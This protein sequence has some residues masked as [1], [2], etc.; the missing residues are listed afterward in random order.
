MNVRKKSETDTLITIEWDQV[1]GQEGYVVTLD[2]SDVLADGRRHFS[3]SRTARSARISKVQDGQPHEYGV[4]I[5]TVQDQGAVTVP[6]PDEPPPPPPGRFR[7]GLGS[8]SDSGLSARIGQEAG[9]H[10]MRS[11][12]W[13][14]DKSASS[15]V[16][17]A[18]VYLDRGIEPIILFNE[19]NPEAAVPANL[20]AI[21][22]ALRPLNVTRFEWTNELLYNYKKGGG[23]AAPLA[24]SAVRASAAL[25]A[26]NPDAK[27][28]MP[29]DNDSGSSPE[30]IVND[31]YQAV[32]D[33]HNAARIYANVFHTYGPPSQY[34]TQKVRRFVAALKAKGQPDTPII[35]TEDG[36]S[37][38]NGRNLS[39]NYGYKTNGTYDEG[40]QAIREKIAYLLADAVIGPRL[41]TFILYKA[42]DQQPPGA[43]TD[44]EW[45]F[46][47]KTSNGQTRKGGMWDATVD[48]ARQHP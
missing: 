11:S 9:V 26:G 19:D 29:F 12:D 4:R 8:S 24:R 5:L 41:E 27:F 34:H 7:F 10:I 25:R 40:G 36:Y 1:P 47:V 3:G 21:A 15:A 42:H 30:Q 39:N 23:F 32:P 45:Y 17:D 46:G 37:S 18:K 14:S 48:L 38:D 43:G 44:R 20:Q 31:M 16:A 33:F 35:I 6:E 22:A 2:G 13:S 28:C